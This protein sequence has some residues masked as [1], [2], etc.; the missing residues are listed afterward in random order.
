MHNSAKG[1][2]PVKETNGSRRSGG[3]GDLDSTRR[4]KELSISW[5]LYCNKTRATVERN[6][7][8]NIILFRVTRTTK[9]IIH[10]NG[11]ILR[12]FYRLQTNVRT[13][14]LEFS[15][16]T[17]TNL[18]RIFS[19][20]YSVFILNIKYLYSNITEINTPAIVLMY[21]YLLF[22]L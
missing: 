18:Y 7:R 9:I 2:R 14:L 10:V 20:K 3:G 16:R 8:N 6:W 12:V 22:Y 13:Y 17:P 21:F 15:F 5:N 1:I 4:P 11:S 19:I